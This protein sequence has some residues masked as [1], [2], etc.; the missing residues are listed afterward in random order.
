MAAAGLGLRKS[1]KSR[2]KSS[3]QSWSPNFE[4]VAEDVSRNPV[5]VLAS[6]HQ[7][8]SSANNLTLPPQQN[9]HAGTLTQSASPLDQPQDGSVQ[10]Q[11][12]AAYYGCL[13]LVPACWE[14]PY[15]IRRGKR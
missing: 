2:A 1:G 5:L 4:Q 10:Y 7:Q 14:R 8:Q 15:Y 11:P 13:G 3:N 6:E 9:Q 12:G